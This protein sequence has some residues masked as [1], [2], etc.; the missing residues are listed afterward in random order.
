M[1]ILTF[2]RNVALKQSRT[3]IDFDDEDAVDD[4]EYE[5]LCGIS[6]EAFLDMFAC[7][8]TRVK[9]TP[10][11]SVK[12]SLAI[13]LIK[14]KS[15]MSNKLIATIFNISRSSV[16]RCIS[17]VRQAL[18]ESFVPQNI[19]FGHVS[20]K[21]IIDKHTRQLA[22]T[23]FTDVSDDQAIL[24]LDGTYIYIHKSANF[25]FQR[26]SFSIHKGRP[27]VKPMVIVSTTGYFVSVLGPYFAKD[28]DASILKHIMKT[29]AEDIRQWIQP[30]DTF[31]V[32]RGF[33]D[34]LAYLEELEV[35]A[36]MPSFMAKGEKQMAEDDAN[37][38]RLVTKVTKSIAIQLLIIRSKSY[39]N[40]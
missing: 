29:N 10:V 25:K 23:L 16:K 11:R 22:K 36:Q 27:L 7:I 3:R 30:E 12:T 2:L 32:D 8:K 1:D 39:N 9:S 24:V 38:S 40:M 21:D 17:T 4:S 18:P 5:S 13:F 14:M 6:K 20:R 37:T 26:K 31:I 15:G 35:K 34:S 33:R 28:N 19:G